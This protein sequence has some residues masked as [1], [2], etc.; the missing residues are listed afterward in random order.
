MNSLWRMFL[1]SPK[2]IHVLKVVKEAL[3]EP[4]LTLI[5]AGD[6]KWKSHY[7]AVDAVKC[8]NLNNTYTSA[9]SSR[10]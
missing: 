7:K 1:V 2:K 6:T 10:C 8:L 4:D 9:S 3:Q 5:R